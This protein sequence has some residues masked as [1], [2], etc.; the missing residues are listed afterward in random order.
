MEKVC[1]LKNFRFGSQGI[2]T[3][4]ATNQ[5]QAEIKN[6]FQNE[7]PGLPKTTLNHQMLRKTSKN[8]QVST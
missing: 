4:I 6:F 2:V 1:F 7:N 8:N 3:Y 5:A